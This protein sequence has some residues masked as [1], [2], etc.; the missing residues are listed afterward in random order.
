M[1]DLLGFLPDQSLTL[2]TFFSGGGLAD[3]GFE[4]AGFRVVFAC[5]ID[6]QARAVHRRHFPNAI[7]RHD[8]KEVRGCDVPPVDVL[9]F[10]SPCQDLSVAGKRVGLEGV[11]SGLFFEAMRI[12]DEMAAPPP[13]I[14]WENVSGA[15]S[16]RSGRDFGTVLRE[17][18]RRWSG[19]AYRV[20]DLQFF[21]V[22][23][24]RRRVYVVGHSGGWERAAA[25]LFEP[26]GLRW[27]PPTRPEAGQNAASPVTAGARKCDRGDGNDN[28][29]AGPLGGRSDRGGW[30]DDF[31][32][33]GAFIP[34]AFGGN[35]T[36]GPIDVATRLG[37]NET[38]SGYRLDFESDT[39][40]TGTLCPGSKAAGSA[41]QQDAEQGLLVAHALR[42]EG[43][44]AS[45]D[46]TGRGTPLVPIAFPARL[47]GTQCAKA[48]DLSPA[49]GASNPV[50]VS[51]RGRN[52]GGTAELSGDRCPSMRASK[53]GGDKPYVLTHRAVRRLMPV[54]CERLTRPFSPTCVAG[55]PST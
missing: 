35:N 55:W 48:V 38:G 11:R 9:F 29:V 2:A 17:M 44:D 8:I 25:I 12:V 30:N 47:S 51:L 39:L 34:I 54:E 19:I 18:A 33:S 23:Q 13:V 28:L 32:R 16:S 5:E 15:L 1:L 31:E 50:A 4:E 20:L 49:L 3:A 53:G 45:E 24:R 41:T 6:R 43:F 40:V 46:G 22:P 10:G 14:I 36:S 37:C 7:M 52:G 42:G 21:G 27:N 26:E